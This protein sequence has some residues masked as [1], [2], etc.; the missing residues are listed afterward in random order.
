MDCNFDIRT[1]KKDG[2][3]VFYFQASDTQK[4]YYHARLKAFL[5]RN[6]GKYVKNKYAFLFH[7][8]PRP[9]IQEYIERYC[10]VYI[11]EEQPFKYMVK[12]KTNLN[13]PTQY[14]DKIEK[15]VKDSQAPTKRV[16]RP[17]R[18]RLKETKRKAQIAE[19]ER[20]K[21]EG[22]R[23]KREG[24]RV[25]AE[26]AAEEKKLAGVSITWARVGIRDAT[27]I[28]EVAKHM[29]DFPGNA[30]IAT[31]AA[32]KIKELEQKNKVQLIEKR[33]RDIIRFLAANNGGTIGYELLREFGIE[34]TG[35]DFIVHG[36]E[37]QKAYLFN[38][39]TIQVP[40]NFTF[41]TE[42]HGKI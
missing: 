9:V 30:E 14:L 27:K 2:K 3:K 36:I 21:E 12:V 34:P 26:N 40:K 38:G 16:G 13:G 6:K 33:K 32:D 24:E 7:E 42:F 29:D 22:A 10:D 31:L 19:I 4:P 37:L 39:Y 11:P 5:E 17:G 1:A 15:K 20:L 18:P 41:Y 23:L 35:A 25:K 28:T 8:D